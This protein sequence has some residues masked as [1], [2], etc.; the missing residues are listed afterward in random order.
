MSFL[1]TESS[2]TPQSEMYEAL[3]L[4]QDALTT[5]S[6]QEGRSKFKDLF[7]AKRVKGGGAVLSKGGEDITNLY[8]RFKEYTDSN[9]QV[10]VAHEEY[11]KAKK[12]S[13][14]RDATLLVPEAAKSLLGV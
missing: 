4:D 14:G 2:I 7:G 8:G 5:F 13:P 11:V 3:E 10:R 9:R 1:E 6:N 12:E